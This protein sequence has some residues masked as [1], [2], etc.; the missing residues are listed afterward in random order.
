M[1]FNINHLSYYQTRADEEFR[2]K[3]K[4]IRPKQIIL[5]KILLSQSYDIPSA[6]QELVPVLL[7]A[8]VVEHV[9]I[10]YAC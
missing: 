3:H 8:V 6:E 4:M 2:N 10:V 7:P 9:S 1:L 5:H